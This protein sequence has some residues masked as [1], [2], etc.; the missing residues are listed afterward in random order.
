MVGGGVN[1]VVYGYIKG[2]G[3]GVE[4]VGIFLLVYVVFVVID[5]KCKVCDF[6]VLVCCLIIYFFGYCR[7]FL[8]WL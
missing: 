5:V 2:G 8:F 1:M 4:I 3:L 7:I 6:Y